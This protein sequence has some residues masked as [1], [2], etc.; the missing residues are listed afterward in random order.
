MN[1]ARLLRLAVA[2]PVIGSLVWIAGCLPT[3]ASS[4]NRAGALYQA[5]R[6][7]DATAEYRRAIALAPDWPPPQLGLGNCL[8]KQSDQRGAIDAYRRAVELAPTYTEAQVVL[9]S[10]LL[11]L[12]RWQEAASQLQTAIAHSPREGRL[13]AMLGRALAEQGNPTGAMEAF[14]QSIRLCGGCMTDAET[15]MYAGLR[16]LPR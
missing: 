13:F 14:D 11:E 9:G 15:R 7:E 3:A 8:R 10:Y 1:L 16:R 4:L 2:I 12:A 6:Y 5:G